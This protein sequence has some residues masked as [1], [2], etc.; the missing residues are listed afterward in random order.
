MAA[1]PVPGTPEAAGSSGFRVKMETAMEKTMFKG[2]TIGI[3][4]MALAVV[5]VAGYKAINPKSADVVAITEI[6]QTIETPRKECKDVQVHQR[7]PA[8]DPN[9]IAGTVIGGV[10]GGV[11]GNQIGRGAGNAVATIAGD[12]GGAYVGNQMQGVTQKSDVVTATKRICKAVYDKSLQVAG[13]DVTY[14]LKGKQEAVRMAYRPGATL[15]VEHGQVI[16][17]PPVA[18]Q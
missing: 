16:V 18:T 4:T 8:S 6:T 2:I 5:G 13:Y 10:A 1:V 11:L 7:A 9:R 17:T 15:P 12:A 14:R 3:A